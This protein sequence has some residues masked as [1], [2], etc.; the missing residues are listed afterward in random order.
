I[1]FCLFTG[2]IYLIAIFSIYQGLEDFETSRI[3]PAIG[4]FLPIFTFIFIYIF[5]GGKEILGIKEIIALIFLIIGSILISYDS[6]K[7]FPF[8]SLKISVLAALFLS[9]MFILSKYVY[10][11]L[12]FWTGFIWIRVGVLLTALLFLFSKAVRKDV[13]TKKSTFNKKTSVIFV[14]NQGFGAS[15]SILQNWGIALAPLVF[16][17]IINALQGVQYLFLFIFTLIF[18]KILKEKISRKIITQKLI[19]IVFII[20]GLILITT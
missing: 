13:F 7:K 18:F 5:S 4:G 11:M 1:I 8:K 3:I 17:P 9:L 12:P 16:L 10:L 15:A 6:K 19:A 14:V 2:I 20:I